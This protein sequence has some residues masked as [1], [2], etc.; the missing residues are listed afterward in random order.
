MKAT[1]LILKSS[2]IK[3]F[4]SLAVL[5]TLVLIILI[6]AYFSPLNT[7][8]NDLNNKSQNSIIYFRIH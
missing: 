2:Y 5:E 4:I 6:L 1:V 8:I 3:L 7:A